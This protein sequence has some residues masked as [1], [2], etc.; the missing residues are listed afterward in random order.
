MQEGIYH[1][2]FSSPQGTSGEGLA[3]IKAG[4]VNGGDGGYLYSGQLAATGDQVAGQLEIKQW[5]HAVP[6]IF[7]Q[8]RKFKLDLKDSANGDTFAV[9][10]GMAGQP[11]LKISIAGRRLAE[12]A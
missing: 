12:A 1:V 4:S 3:V 8:L 7:G 9:S 6:S 11:N 5:N 2:R 10:G